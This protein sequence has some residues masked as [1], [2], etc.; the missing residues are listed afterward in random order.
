MSKN[1]LEKIDEAIDKEETDNALVKTDKEIAKVE[2]E[3][4]LDLLHFIKAQ[5]SQTMAGNSV[6]DEALKK[7]T[8]RMNKVNEQGQEE[9]SDHTLLRIV[10]IFLRHEN[11]QSFNIMNMMKQ[12]TV[13]QN[14]NHNGNQ[15]V[16]LVESKEVIGLTKEELQSAKKV[17][18]F[19]SKAF[20]AEFTVEEKDK[21]AIKKDEEEE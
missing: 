21:K 8:A 17:H 11:D 1:L 18:N 14:F 4:R 13:N 16:R 15:P 6:K 9:M 20:D 19:F 5:I 12:T 2:G 3:V 10:E 7:L